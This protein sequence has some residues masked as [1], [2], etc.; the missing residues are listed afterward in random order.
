MRK[1]ILLVVSDPCKAILTFSSIFNI[2][3]LL[4]VINK[5]HLKNHPPSPP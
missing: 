3:D 5:Y 2:N 1:I 4:I